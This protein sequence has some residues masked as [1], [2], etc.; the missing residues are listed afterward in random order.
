MPSLEGLTPGSGVYLNEANLE[1]PNLEQDLYGANYPKLLQVKKKWDPDNLF[2]AT[3]AVGSEAFVV[4][5]NGG[6]CRTG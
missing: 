5:A 2:Y 1:Q 4:A 6:L 3:T